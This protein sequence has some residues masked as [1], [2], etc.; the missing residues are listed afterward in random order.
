MI[1]MLSR[2]CTKI[3]WR[4]VSDSVGVVMLNAEVQTFP[5]LQ[6]K[7]ALQNTHYLLIKS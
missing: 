1:R 7:L 5:D 2:Y 4:I 6:A 3:A